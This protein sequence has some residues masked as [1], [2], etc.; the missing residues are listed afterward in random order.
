[1]EITWT[2]PKP[3][4]EITHFKISFMGKNKNNKKHLDYIFA[5]K[6]NE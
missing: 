1:M 4:K 3:T 6:G 5:I 2:T